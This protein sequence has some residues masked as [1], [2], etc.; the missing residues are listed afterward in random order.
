MEVLAKDLKKSVDDLVFTWNIKATLFQTK[1]EARENA[2]AM[3]TS[4]VNMVKTMLVPELKDQ[5]V[6]NPLSFLAT[7]D[8]VAAIDAWSHVKGECDKKM[9]E[10]K[11]LFEKKFDTMAKQLR[12][13]QVIKDLT[14]QQDQ[15]IESVAK[16]DKM[17]TGLD[18]TSAKTGSVIASI[19]TQLHEDQLKNKEGTKAGSN[20]FDL[21]IKD[22][23][24]T[25]VSGSEWDISRIRAMI[26]YLAATTS[27]H[28]EDAKMSTSSWTEVV[29]GALNQLRISADKRLTRA[30][31]WSIVKTLDESP[32]VENLFTKMRRVIDDCDHEARNFD[33][34]KFQTWA[35]CSRHRSTNQEEKSSVLEKKKLKKAKRKAPEDDIPEME[36]IPREKKQKKRAKASIEN[37]IAPANFEGSGRKKKAAN[38]NRPAGQS[39]KWLQMMNDLDQMARGGA[40]SQSA[41]QKEDSESESETEKTNSGNESS[42]SS[43]HE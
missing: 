36:T 35:R 23:V 20:T 33:G 34:F 24:T 4:M 1:A 25:V 2:T 18:K 28:A 5:F 11:D 41:S 3:F 21:V 30:E 8:Q 14:Q 19:L 13:Q 22:L 15:L 43:D 16:L 9:V 26:L 40:P 7:G 12:K 37:N 27:K 29:L 38:K 6:A 32:E 17:V 39:D 10:F 31:V 42:D